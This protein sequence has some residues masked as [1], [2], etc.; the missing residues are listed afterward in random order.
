LLN[1]VSLIRCSVY[2]KVGAFGKWKKKM[3][4]EDAG[5]DNDVNALVLAENLRV[6]VGKFVR[7][8]KAEANTPT[9]SQSETLSLLDREGPLS[10]AELADRRNV[11]HQS[12]RLV[13]VQLEAEGLISKMPNPADGRSQLLSIT[14]K[15]EKVLSRAREARASQIASLI[16]DRLSAEDRQTL[17]DAVGIIERLC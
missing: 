13:A 9:T 1:A 15:G 12:M 14:D 6:A 5:G 10:V 2:R 8:I 7:S 17:S 4:D 11:K 16:N 3:V